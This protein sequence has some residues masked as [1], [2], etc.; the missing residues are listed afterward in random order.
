MVQVRE[1][2]RSAR[3]TVEQP[4]RPPVMLQ[5]WRSLLFM[6]W[7]VPAQLLKPMLPTDLQLD[8]FQRDAWIGL[9]PFTMTGIRNPWLPAVPGLNAMHELNVRTYVRHGE[10]A[11]VWFLSLDAAHA[12]MVQV[13][14]TFYHLPYYRASMDLSKTGSRIAY[15]SRRTHRG[16]AAARFEAEWDIENSLP[17]STPGSLEYFLTERYCLLTAHKGK[18]YQ[19]R[20]HHGPWPLHR[21]R[22]HHFRSSMLESHGIATPSHEPLLHYADE[23]KVR[24]WPLKSLSRLRD[25][26]NWKTGCPI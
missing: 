1:A 18:L 12:L 21:A 16:A 26:R 5:T 9:V 17:L 14:R 6:H 11:G 2:L 7:T 8:T 23:L 15:S 22:L 4:D 25:Q 20:I 13:A 24:I 19:G 10:T 3:D